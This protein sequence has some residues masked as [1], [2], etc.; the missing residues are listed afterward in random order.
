MLMHMR[1]LGSA[2]LLLITISAQA[3]VIPGNRL[4]PFGQVKQF[5]QLSDSQVQSIL[6]NN[7][8]YNRWAAEKQAR[9]L[10]VQSEIAEETAKDP[11]DPGALGIRYAEIEM[12]CRQMRDRT[13]EG[14]AKNLAVLTPDQRTKLKVLEDA[15]ALAPAITEAQYGNLAGELGAASPV[16][17]GTFSGI[18]GGILGAVIGSVNGCQQ[19]PTR[20]FNT[21]SFV[22]P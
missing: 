20:W 22:T 12:I 7:D 21:G 2:L 1:L 6:A 13:R 10:Q 14:R 11:L 9:V 15:L 8:E 19:A 18:G 3:Q 4:S 16:Y 17:T 5:L